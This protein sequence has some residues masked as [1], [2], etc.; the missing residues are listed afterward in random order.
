MP[1]PTSAPSATTTP[2][3]RSA[4]STGST[5]AVLACRR[6]CWATCATRAAS[7]RRAMASRWCSISPHWSAFPTATSRPNPSSRRTSAA[8][9]N[10]L[11]AVRRR[12]LRAPGAHLDERGLRHPRH[13]PD[14]RVASAQG[15]VAL[16]RQQ[17][18]RGQAVRGVRQQLRGSGRRASA[19]QHVR[20]PAVGTGGHPDHPRAAPE[21]PHGDPPRQPHAPARSHVHERYHRGVSRGRPL[22][23]SRG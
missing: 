4:G 14:P 1:A 23:R 5:R 13:A 11:E 16:Q 22:S 10:V 9:M 7:R 2:T 3:A 17:D 19:V 15:P 6:R 8:R 12:G 20:A 21:R 18:R